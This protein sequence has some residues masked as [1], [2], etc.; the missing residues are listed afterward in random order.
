MCKMN[1]FWMDADDVHTRLS[2]S[3]LNSYGSGYANHHHLYT[4]AIDYLQQQVGQGRI[5]LATLSRPDRLPLHSLTL[6]RHILVWML[7]DDCVGGNASCCWEAS[8]E[9]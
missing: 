6:T 5:A 1:V 3:I 2:S 9:Q 7:R 8:K 4:D